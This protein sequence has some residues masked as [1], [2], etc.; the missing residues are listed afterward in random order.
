MLSISIFA[1]ITLLTLVLG[2]VELDKIEDK[3]AMTKWSFCGA[4]ASL[5]LVATSSM[6]AALS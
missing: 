6:A 1:S 2:L 5:F 3:S 4:M